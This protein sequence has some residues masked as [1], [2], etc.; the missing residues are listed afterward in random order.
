MDSGTRLG[1]AVVLRISAEEEIPGTSVGPTSLRITGQ[2]PAAVGIALVRP[3][4]LRPQGQFAPAPVSVARTSGA[5]TP[6]DR[7]SAIPLSPDHISVTPPSDRFRADAL[8]RTRTCSAAH[9]S[10][11][12]AASADM[13]IT[14]SATA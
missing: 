14:D 5:R 11:L 3:G 2:L 12:M 4:A 8:D 10:I 13:G 1:T 7:P 6:A 9:A